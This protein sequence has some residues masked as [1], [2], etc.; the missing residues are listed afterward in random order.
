MSNAPIAQESTSYEVVEQEPPEVMARNL[1]AAGYLLAGATAFFFVAFLFGYFYLR[2]LNNAGMWKPK[3]VDGSIGWGTAVVAC[4]IVSALLV[5]LAVTDQ[6]ADRRPQWRLK[7][8]IALLAGVAGLV[9]QVFAWT[10]E[11]FG[12]ADGGY[13]SIYF[14]WT[15]FLFLFVLGAMFWLEITLATS[16]RYRNEPFGAA[17]VPA[18]HASGDPHRAA[19]DIE[20]PVD[21]N[22]AELASLSFYWTFLAAI[23]VVAWVILYLL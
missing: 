8:L 9:V 12:P 3:G 17:E 7:G 18:G 19:H 10:H 14:G 2:S 4:Y 21:V 11:G 16:W 1:V 23:A 22:R 6:A 20:N 5:R 15:A 13:A